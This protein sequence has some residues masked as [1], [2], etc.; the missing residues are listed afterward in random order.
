VLVKIRGGGKIFVQP[1]ELAIQ[2]FEMAAQGLLG[3]FI[4]NEDLQADAK[5]TLSFTSGRAK[6]LHQ[7]ISHVNWPK[8][9]VSFECV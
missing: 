9:T 4:A 7:D 1:V 6:F 2:R 3:D 5:R 8:N